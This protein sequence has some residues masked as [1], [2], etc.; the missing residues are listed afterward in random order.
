MFVEKG[1]VIFE[2]QFG[3]N[4]MG[5]LFEQVVFFKKFVL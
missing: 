5:I 3:M 4:K 1:V 2:L